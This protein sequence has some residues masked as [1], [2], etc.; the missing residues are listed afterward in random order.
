M[1]GTGIFT[2]ILLATVFILFLLKFDRSEDALVKYAGS[3]YSF[4]ISFF[5][6]LVLMVM[7]TFIAFYS[8]YTNKVITGALNSIEI[9]IPYVGIDETLRLKSQ[10]HQMKSRKDYAVFYSRMKSIEG[11]NGVKLSLTDP[12]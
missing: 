2:G 3:K 4:P 9:V 6:T 12:L 8:S 11:K 5:I 7:V 10:F 1:L